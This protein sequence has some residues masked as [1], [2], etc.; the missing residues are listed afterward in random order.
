MLKSDETKSFSVPSENQAIPH[1]LESIETT[2]NI[3][4]SQGTELEHRNSLFLFL[5]GMITI[6][7]CKMR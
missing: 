2:N 5:W 1:W 7:H 3:L 4:L 6:E